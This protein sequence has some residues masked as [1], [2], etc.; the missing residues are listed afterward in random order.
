VDPIKREPGA[1]A[2]NPEGFVKIA[3][4]FKG[5]G[6]GKY[7]AYCVLRK[8]HGDTPGDDEATGTIEFA[9]C[10]VPPRVALITSWGSRLACP[11]IATRAR[12]AMLEDLRADQQHPPKGKRTGGPPADAMDVDDNATDNAT[13]TATDNDNATGRS[14]PART[15][16]QTTWTG[17]TPAHKVAQRSDKKKTAKGSSTDG[18]ADG[19]QTGQHLQALAAKDQE[20]A[21]LRK[22]ALTRQRASAEADVHAARQE[23]KTKHLT[24]TIVTLKA[25]LKSERTLV[26][27]LSKS[28]GIP[29]RE[30]ATEE[31]RTA[32]PPDA[33]RMGG[34]ATLRGFA[35]GAHE[36]LG[37]LVYPM[38]PSSS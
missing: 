25:D 33:A 12:D 22:D 1:P 37:S 32:D 17:V 24:A 7:Q 9:K 2:T 19:R 6:Q 16:T 23:E 11:D 36:H 31:E 10:R 26:T 35:E 13:D 15:K 38:P 5:S 28:V 3:L 8:V 20:I 14:A 21:T 27:A 18:P 34:I 30:Q 29:S 4:F